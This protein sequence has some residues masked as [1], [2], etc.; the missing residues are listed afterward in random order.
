MTST[1]DGDIVVWDEQGAS[2]PVGT[3]ASDRR[4][5]K[6]RRSQC[7]CMCSRSSRR[8]M[9]HEKLHVRTRVRTGRGRRGQSDIS[10]IGRGRGSGRGSRCHQ[11]QPLRGKCPNQSQPQVMRV[12]EKAIPFLGTIG[13]F[14][15]TGGAD[16]LVSSRLA[17]DHCLYFKYFIKCFHW[18]QLRD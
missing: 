5:V 10:A 8:I 2:A 14:V 3:R 18:L 15:V 13:S 4:A 17:A 9:Q 11:V 12:H 6:V 1:A 16:G 7:P